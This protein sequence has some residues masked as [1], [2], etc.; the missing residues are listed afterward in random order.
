[1][2][3]AVYDGLDTRDKSVKFF[4]TWL[5]EYEFPYAIILKVSFGTNDACAN[6]KLEFPQYRDSQSRGKFRLTKTGVVEISEN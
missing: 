3:S 5:G 4:I 6:L 2:D 1:M